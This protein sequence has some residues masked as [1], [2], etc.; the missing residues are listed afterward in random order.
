M[1][2]LKEEFMDEFKMIR[3]AVYSD[4]V[5]C[6]LTFVSSILNRNRECSEII[7]KSLISV[8]HGLGFTDIHTLGLLEK[9]FIK[10]R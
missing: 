9:Y 3:T 7:A 5:G 10:E 4:T 8:R 6:D 2:K 1:Y